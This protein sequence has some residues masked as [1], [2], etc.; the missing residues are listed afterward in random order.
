MKNKENKPKR[1]PG[2]V[3][4]GL[5]NLLLRLAISPLSFVF[6]L[7][8]VKYLSDISAVTF[9]AWQTMFVLIT[10]Y[11]V[12]PADIFSNI[13]SRYAAEGK[14]VGG[15]LLI[16]GIAGVLAISI[17]LLIIPF[18]NPLLGGNFAKYFYFSSILVFLFYIFD[19][20][21]SIALGR[22]PRVNA[23]SASVFQIIRLIAGIILMFIFNLSIFAVIL[24]YSLGYI[25]QILINILF[26]NANLQIDLKIAFKAI[27]KSIVFITSY[28]QNIIEASLVWIAVYL[29]R[30]ALPV[31][32]FESALI[33][34]N[35]VIWSGSITDGL[36][37]KLAENKDPDLLE[38]ATKLFFLAGS[39]FLLLTFVD[40]DPLLFIL[41]P[42]YIEAFL[43][44][45]VLSISNFLRGLY[46]IFYRGIYMADTT[47]S[48]EGSGELKGSTANLIRRNIFISIIGLS[49]STCLMIILKTF[50]FSSPALAIAITLGLLINSI[51]MLTTAYISAKNIYRLIFP[52]IESIVPLIAT[53]VSSLP[54]LIRYMEGNLPKF[55]A[56][57]EIEIMLIYTLISSSIFVIINIALNPYARQLFI[58]IIKRIKNL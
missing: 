26:S 15:I 21:R 33:I 16:N 34:S 4:I 36:I 25:A 20:T 23:I 10:G 30:T 41:R 5:F 11:F 2:L 13:T 38:T 49:F 8:M 54:F 18:I 44:L 43:A 57:H 27:K 48:T 29:V 39:F 17:Y 9:G 40:G 1:K 46:T 12:I 58:M 7:L 47:L 42:E 35:I 31:S 45:I 53:V 50:S 52:K 32:Y 37:L 24:A 28:I 55:R 3:R 56:I 14:K 51:G 19:I 22:S 6:S